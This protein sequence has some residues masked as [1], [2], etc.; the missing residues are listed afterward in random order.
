[1]IVSAADLI[2]DSIVCQDCL[3][4]L[5]SDVVSSLIPLTEIKWLLRF[6]VP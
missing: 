3:R 6:L 4:G 1:M 5:F 2:M